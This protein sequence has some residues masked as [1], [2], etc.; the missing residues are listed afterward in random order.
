ML[1]KNKEGDHTGDAAT[2]TPHRLAWQIPRTGN[3]PLQMARFSEML[4]KWHS[5]NKALRLLQW[6][7][8]E[9]ERYTNANGRWVLAGGGPWT[10]QDFKPGKGL[11]SRRDILPL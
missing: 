11:S 2:S 1:Y 8:G 4:D 5:N 7:L 10:A 3:L 6:D 9:E